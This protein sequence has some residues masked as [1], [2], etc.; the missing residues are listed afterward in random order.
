MNVVWLSDQISLQRP[1]TTARWMARVT[2]HTKTTTQHF[3]V[4]GSFLDIDVTAFLNAVVEVA[5]FLSVNGPA[6]SI[7]TRAKPGS[8]VTRDSGND[9]IRC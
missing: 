9:P 8:G 6:K 1:L 7:P 4:V 3:I 5:V 2:K